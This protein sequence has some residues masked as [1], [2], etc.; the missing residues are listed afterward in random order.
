MNYLKTFAKAYKKDN[1]QIKAIETPIKIDRTLL[2]SQA[3]MN[4]KLWK[5]AGYETAPTIQEMIKELS[6]FPYR[7]KIK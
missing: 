6:E 3:L 7:F 5:E 4:W 1:Y 2:T